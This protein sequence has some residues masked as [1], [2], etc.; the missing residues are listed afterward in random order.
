MISFHFY[1]LNTNFIFKNKAITPLL[2]IISLDLN[3]RSLICQTK[4]PNWFLRKLID[5]HPD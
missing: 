5:A 2:P 4:S 3:L 1:D